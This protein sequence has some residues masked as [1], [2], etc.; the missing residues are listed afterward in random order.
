MM[1]LARQRGLA[2]VLQAPEWREIVAPTSHY[3]IAPGLNMS[4]KSVAFTAS[5]SQL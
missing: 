2:E 3:L 5:P 4:D 1:M